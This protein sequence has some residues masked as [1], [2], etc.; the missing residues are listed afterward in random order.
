M[1]AGVR[2]DCSSSVRQGLHRYGSTRV[3][4]VSA[5]HQQCSLE[6]WQRVLAPIS[7]TLV[8]CMNTNCQGGVVEAF[9]FVQLAALPCD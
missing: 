3:V 4:C 1:S 6:R 7:A 8:H 5:Q 9:L 2:A